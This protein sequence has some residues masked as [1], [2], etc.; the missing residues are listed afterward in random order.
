M[1]RRLIAHKLERIS[2]RRMESMKKN[3]ANIE[4][5]IRKIDSN[6]ESTAQ[7]FE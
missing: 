2:R 6:I 7:L 5:W 1:K 4:G 3:R